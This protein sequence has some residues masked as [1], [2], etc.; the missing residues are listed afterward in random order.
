MHQAYTSMTHEV[1]HMPIQYH[2]SPNNLLDPE[3]TIV[4]GIRKA[5]VGH[6]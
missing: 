3:D 4:L 5:H 2:Q 6:L 1:K